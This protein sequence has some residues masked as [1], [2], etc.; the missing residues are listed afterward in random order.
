MHYVSKQNGI[1]QLLEKTL[2]V[3]VAF[4]DKNPSFFEDLLASP[5]QG[6]IIVMV[7]V[8]KAKD[9]VSTAF[10][11]E[12]NMGSDETG[13]AGHKDGV[14]GGVDGMLSRCD[15][16]NNIRWDLGLGFRFLVVTAVV[17]TAE[18]EEEGK[19]GRSCEKDWHFTGFYSSQFA[20]QMSNS[21]ND[22]KRL[23][24]NTDLSWLVCGGLNKIMYAFEKN[25]GLPREEMKMELFRETL[26]D[27]QLF[28][29][30]YSRP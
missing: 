14:T 17:A 10:K 27:C 19:K 30:G 6:W 4:D 13:G 28:D 3:D 20:S 21:W 8:V 18:K 16:W 25:E 9:T 12:G 24:L 29:K 11:S 15:I 2:V 5:F 23:G 1:E 22:L 7:K 26:E